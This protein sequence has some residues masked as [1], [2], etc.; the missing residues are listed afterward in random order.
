MYRT[1][2]P[3]PKFSPAPPKVQDAE[4]FSTE[5]LPLATYLHATGA[6]PFIGCENSVPG[7]VRVVFADPDHLGDQ[8]ELEFDRGAAVPAT[9]IFA[10]QRFLRRLM[11]ETLGNH[12]RKTEYRKH[13]FAD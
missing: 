11:T 10:S 7:K 13:G 1:T 9:A 8:L 12:P 6:L 4:R 3:L 2:E 5:R